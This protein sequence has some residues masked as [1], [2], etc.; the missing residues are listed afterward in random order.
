MANTD[1]YEF[2]FDELD[3]MAQVYDYAINESRNFVEDR[4]V[5][6][7]VVTREA[8]VGTLR[9]IHRFPLE[10]AVMIADATG[11]WTRAEQ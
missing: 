6:G 3:Q 8:L 11:L 10:D 4:R 7:Q 5:L 9:V 2:E 1:Q